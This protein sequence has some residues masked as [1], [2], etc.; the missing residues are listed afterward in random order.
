MENIQSTAHTNPTSRIKPRR[1]G[2]PCVRCRQMKVSSSPVVLGANASSL[3][4]IIV[5]SLKPRHGY[6]EGE[7]SYRTPQSEASGPEPT[8]PSSTPRGPLPGSDSSL[9]S[10]TAELRLGW[11]RSARFTHEA[12]GVSFTSSIVAELLEEYYSHVHPRFPL[13]LEPASIVDSYEKAP[14]L[15]W[16]VLAIASKDLEKYASDYARLQILLRQLVADIVLLG[17]RSIFL[18]Q[19]LILLCVWSFPHEDMNREPFSMYLAIAISMARSLGLHRPQYPFLMFAAK[20]S[21]IG[22]MESRAATWLSCFIV[23]QWHSARFGVPGSIRADHAILHSLNGSMPGVSATTRIQ[24]HIAVVTSKIST[25]LGECESSPTGLMADPLPLV[26]VFETELCMIQDRYA[27]Q[28][29]PADEVSFL[30]ARL[31]L[32][33]YIL[34]RKKTEP[35]KNLYPDN[36]F[37]VQGSITARQLLIVLTTFP[38][39]LTKGTIHVFRAAS[40]AV[41]FLLRVLGTAPSEL[42]DE[43]GIRNIIRQTFTLL[44]DISQSANDRRSQCVRVCRI[45]EN[46]IEYE[47]WNKD[48]PF[49]GKAESFMSLNFIAD[50]AARGIMKANI[51]HAAAQAERDCREDV[52]AAAPPGVSNFDFDFSIFDP[53]GW[54][55]NWRN[56]G[57]PLFVNE[58]LSGPS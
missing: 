11:R 21:D 38:D 14:L 24:L 13:L 35:L 19:A 44:R 52:V 34:G 30:D 3:T 31:S 2:V 29:S 25:A 55:V 18:V 20:A 53:M 58:D 39:A 41:F 56:S 36:E 43:T 1:A 57:D 8:D 51:R 40:Y 6:E 46:M 26:R 33:S 37:I 28:W 49:L 32:Y 15:F 16:T 42:I 48:T 4:L 10:I 9:T 5:L 22:T 50:V 12:T 54:D 27:C 7:S 45:I 23:D 47:D 17:T